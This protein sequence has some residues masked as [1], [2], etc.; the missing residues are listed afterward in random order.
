MTKSN[1]VGTWYYS[2]ENN[3]YE[4]WIDTPQGHL[5]VGAVFDQAVADDICSRMNQKVLNIPSN[6]SFMNA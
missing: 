4:L 3:C 2:A 1:I 6:F 5:Q